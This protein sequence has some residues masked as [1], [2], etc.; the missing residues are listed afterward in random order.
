M[1]I[2]P[3]G[4]LRGPI[5]FQHGEPLCGN[6]DLVAKLNAIAQ[7]ASERME[8]GTP[9]KLRIDYVP[10]IGYVFRVVM[11]RTTATAGV[12]QFGEV[13]SATTI[14]AGA[15][16]RYLIQLGDL[17]SDGDLPQT[18]PDFDLCWTLRGEDTRF[19]TVNSYGLHNTS[20]LLT[21]GEGADMTVTGA[22]SKER[23][24]IGVGAVVPLF[25]TGSLWV[26]ADP[27]NIG[28]GCG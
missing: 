23:R 6:P 27:N 17:T 24:A 15:R 13:I 25:W 28:T 5:T 22:W 2:L 20:G 16:W 26:M 19:Y 14:I 10:G 11:P 4:I 9:D 18:D 1:P 21:G 3:P 8:S 7:T 12:T